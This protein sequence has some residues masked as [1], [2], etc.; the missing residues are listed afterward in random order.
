MAEPVHIAL[1]D[2][3]SA[4]LDSLR[5]YFESREIRTSCFASPETFLAAFD[6]DLQPDCIVSDVRL[7]GRS[8]LDLVHSLNER[9]SIV[10]II[11][12][13]GVGD[14]TMA[15]SAMRKGA[16]DFIEKPFDERHL[17]TVIRS[18]VTAKRL[19]SQDTAQ[20]E[21]LRSR[22]NT[23][24]SR[25]RQVMEL[26]VAGLSNKEIASQL[27]ISAK[28]VEIHRA[29]VMERMDAKNLVELVRIGLKLKEGA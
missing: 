14:I 20:I 7:T 23:L 26:A 28:T 21:E 22:F 4:V 29:W 27:D 2:D 13:T 25:Q 8:G 17:L 19:Q 10:P 6:S 3:D 12:M 11:L 9:R 16:F 1:V 24:S 15:V 18:A 5:C